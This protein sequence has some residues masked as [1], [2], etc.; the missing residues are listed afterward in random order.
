MDKLVV[1]CLLGDPALPAASIEHTGG[2]QIDVQE[3]LNS[4]QNSEC[5]VY[6]INYKYVKVL[7]YTV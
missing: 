4:I 3:L 2:F 7:S 1:L 5:V 6:I